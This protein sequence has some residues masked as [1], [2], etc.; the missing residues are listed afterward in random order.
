MS[1]EYTPPDELPKDEFQ[2]F[3]SIVKTQY[4]KRVVKWEMG[5]HRIRLCPL[6]PSVTKVYNGIALPIWRHQVRTGSGT[7][8]YLC[9]NRNFTELAPMMGGKQEP[10]KCPMCEI[11]QNAKR[12]GLKDLATEAYARMVWVNWVIDRL[13]EDAGPK[14]MFLP[15][16]SLYIPIT[17]LVGR[18]AKYLAMCHPTQGYDI[19]YS[20][21]KGTGG[22]SDYTG[23]SFDDAPS[24][25][26]RDI[27]KVLEFVEKNPIASVFQYHTP[28]H[29]KQMFGQQHDTGRFDTPQE[30]DEV[31]WGSS[32]LPSKKSTPTVDDW[33]SSLSTLPDVDEDIPF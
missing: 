9:H 24:P 28:E 17:T 7:S 31:E 26:F 18:H 23:I 27:N 14:I 19:M 11:E 15:K 2:T 4:A 32:P 30:P 22:F 8:Y 3:D 6:P 20:C 5:E 10:G 13:H 1:F 33:D 25:L 21:I 16:K 12:A 29:I